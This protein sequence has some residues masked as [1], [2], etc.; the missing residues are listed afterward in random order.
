[1]NLQQQLDEIIKTMNE[2]KKAIHADRKIAAE[3]WAGII[4]AETEEISDKIIDQ[5]QNE[6][7]G[8]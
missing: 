6:S 8:K 1:M 7:R 5:M 3:L 2:L 4:E